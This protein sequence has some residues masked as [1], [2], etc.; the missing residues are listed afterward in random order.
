MSLAEALKINP[1][2]LQSIY[3]R[4]KQIGDEGAKKLAECRNNNKLY[5][6]V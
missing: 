2:I 3:L 4:Y 1:A 6:D 5:I